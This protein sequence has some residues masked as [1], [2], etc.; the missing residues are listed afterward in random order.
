MLS[1]PHSAISL[2]R[3]MLHVDTTQRYPARTV[4]ED[5]WIMVSWSAAYFMAV[6]ISIMQVSLVRSAY[7]QAF[8][9]V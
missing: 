8:A 6:L 1:F 4:Q 2:I 7:L 9:I 3:G 5:A